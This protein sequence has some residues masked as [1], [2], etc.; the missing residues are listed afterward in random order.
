[1][2]DEIRKLV[3]R[4]LTHV[5]AFPWTDRGFTNNPNAKEAATSQ[6]IEA[7]VRDIMAI[8]KKEKS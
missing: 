7:T 2:E 3:E 6:I 4:L 8:V 1:M 5:E